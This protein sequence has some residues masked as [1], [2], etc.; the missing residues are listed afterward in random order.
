LFGSV[1]AVA[2]RDETGENFDLVYADEKVKANFK[3]RN[4][5]FYK[6]Q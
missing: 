5:I 3:T 4:Q 1:L 6:K 2:I